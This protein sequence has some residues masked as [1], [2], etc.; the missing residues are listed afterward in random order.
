[1][2]ISESLAQEIAAA[3]F[4]SLSLSLDGAD[5][6]THNYIRNNPHA[7]QTV[8]RNAAFLQQYR[9]RRNFC[10]NLSTV[11]TSRNLG[12]L[13]SLVKL[14]DTL[15]D[16][17]MFQALDSNFGAAYSPSWFRENEFWPSDVPA[18]CAAIDELILMKKQGY[19]VNNSFEQLALMKE[20]IVIPA[21]V[22]VTFATPARRI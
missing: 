15:F 9:D 6:V 17:I 22:L 1:M 16:T 5:A 4:S 8:M 7:F 13:K 20:Y 21:H 10:V 11:I 19:P 3:G 12:Q 18:L 14:T 2:L